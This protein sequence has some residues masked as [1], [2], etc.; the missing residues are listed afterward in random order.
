[1]QRNERKAALNNKTRYY[2]WFAITYTKRD[3]Q[4]PQVHNITNRS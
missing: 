3:V 1:M 4:V 2:D